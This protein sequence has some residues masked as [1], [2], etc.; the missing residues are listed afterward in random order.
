MRLAG[1]VE[2]GLPFGLPVIGYAPASDRAVLEF[3]YLHIGRILAPVTAA[4]VTDLLSGR[5]ASIG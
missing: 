5:R 3:G 2:L 1:T 4:I